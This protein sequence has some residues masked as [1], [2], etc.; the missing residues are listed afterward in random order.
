M[1]KNKAFIFY[2]FNFKFNLN[3]AKIFL[4]VNNFLSSFTEDLLRKKTE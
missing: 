1:N 2:K 4:F 3:T